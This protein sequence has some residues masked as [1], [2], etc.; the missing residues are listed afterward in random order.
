MK[1]TKSKF[2]I[3]K[4]FYNDKFVMLFSIV[5]AF[6]LWINV[7]ATSQETRYLTVT[8][9]PVSLPELGN[10]LHFFGTDNLFAGLAKQ[11]VD[12]ILET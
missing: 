11:I 2:S 9:I 5:L 7:S 6:I 12:H 8:D 10:D 3:G 4:L 1:G